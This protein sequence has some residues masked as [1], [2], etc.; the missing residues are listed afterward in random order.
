MGERLIALGCILLT[1]PILLLAAII[2]VVLSRRSPFVAHQRVGYG[3][4]PIWVLKLRTMWK[5]D[6]P[7]PFILI[8]RLPAA[9]V[10][11]VAPQEKHV[12]VTSR[13]AAACRRF[14]ID[15]LPQ[16]WQVCRGEMALVGP[17]PLTR[18]ELD[19][20]YGADASCIVAARPGL[21]GLWQIS[22]RSRL[23]YA[24][25]RR[26]DL[27]LVRNPCISLYLRI[28]LVTL[29]RVLSGKDAW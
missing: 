28:L 7:G 1:S 3:G 24:Q 12:R 18:Q 19:T 14:S 9:E 11:L 17:R 29:E 8:H 13:F 25:R 21:T 5:G 23:T 26:L 6:P 16:L 2:I 27:F 22:G 20:Y 4:K 15:E 10:P